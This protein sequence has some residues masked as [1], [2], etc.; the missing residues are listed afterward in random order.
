[1][2]VLGSEYVCMWEKGMCMYVCMFVCVCV[3]VYACVFWIRVDVGRVALR[4]SVCMCL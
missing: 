3:G 2:Y 1:M 4:V